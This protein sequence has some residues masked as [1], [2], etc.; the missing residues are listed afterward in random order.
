[1]NHFTLRK[2]STVM[3]TV[4]FE[5]PKNQLKI[6]CFAYVLKF[7]IYQDIVMHLTENA[8]SYCLKVSEEKNGEMIIN[9]EKS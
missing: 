7:I 6:R 5:L 2:F 4:D 8:F 9:A 3:L 1:M